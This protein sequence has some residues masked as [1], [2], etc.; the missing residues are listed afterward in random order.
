MS[1]QVTVKFKY[2]KKTPTVSSQWSG[3]V[4]GK[5]ESAVMQVLKKLHKDCEI[6]IIE[7]KWK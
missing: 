6:V 2:G 5:S 3:T 7:M 4:Q 1:A